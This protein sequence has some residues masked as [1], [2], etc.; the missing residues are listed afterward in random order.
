MVGRYARGWGR[1]TGRFRTTGAKQDAVPP[2]ER[3]EISEQHVTNG[4]EM[5]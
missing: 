1:R 5:V 2:Q 4:A 3:Q